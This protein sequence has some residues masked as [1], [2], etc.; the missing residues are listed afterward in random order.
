MR[1]PL[2][3][4]IRMRRR[5]QKPRRQLCRPGQ[6]PLPR[7][8]RRS[9]SR[10]SR[11]RPLF[12]NRYRHRV[13]S[14]SNHRGPDRHPFSHLRPRSRS[15]RQRR[16]QFRLRGPS[17]LQPRGPRQLRLPSQHQRPG[18]N[19]RQHPDQRRRPGQVRLRLLSPYRHRVPLSQQPLIKA[20]A[21]SRRS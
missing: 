2:L 20:R 4:R 8:K 13:L 1:P 9:L 21:T 6:G 15:R 7:L 18:P 3:S 11:L 5:L 19:R 10:W 14:Q 16:D 17:R 12:S